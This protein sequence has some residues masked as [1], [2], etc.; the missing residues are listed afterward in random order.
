MTSKMGMFGDNALSKR[1]AVNRSFNTLGRKSA[2]RSENLRQ[3]H[4]P[5][6]HASHSA[7]D[8]G[9]ER[10]PTRPELPVLPLNKSREELLPAPLG[11]ASK[12]SP[13]GRSNAV[14]TPAQSYAQHST[15]SNLKPN[16]RVEQ[17]SKL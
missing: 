12:P 10:K 11:G 5:A 9:L 2:R 7:V 4:D 13:H 15:V 17:G 8:L 6:M 14:E 1:N 16:D 3:S